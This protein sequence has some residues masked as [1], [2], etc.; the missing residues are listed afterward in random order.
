[1]VCADPED[2]RIVEGTYIYGIYQAFFISIY[3]FV[4][5]LCSRIIILHWLDE[6]K[7]SL[8]T[9]R[10]Q[11]VFCLAVGAT[12]RA[13]SFIDADCVTEEI[14]RFLKDV[15]WM[16][17]FVLIV[18]FWVELQT[19]VQRMS[20]IEKLK[21]YL[22]GI[23]SMYCFFR[24]LTSLAELYFEGLKN[25]FN[26]LTV[27][28]YLS[29]MVIGQYYG[30]KLLKK[31][32][33]IANKEFK[34]QLIRLTIFIILE[35]IVLLLLLG[36]FVI[37]TFFFSSAKDDKP[38]LWFWL[39]TVEKVLEVISIIVLCLTM[40]GK[41]SAKKKP[42]KAPPVVASSAVRRGRRKKGTSTEAKAKAGETVVKE[43]PVKA[44]ASS[45]ALL[46]PESNS[47]AAVELTPVGATAPS[48]AAA[49]APDADA[50]ASASTSTS[51]S[52]NP[53]DKAE[54]AVAEP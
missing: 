50:S 51:T 7:L 39:K 4:G 53:G 24:F 48:A 6:K 43:N 21:P 18:L 23:M 17:A 30:Q 3:L 40:V 26:G 15:F 14:F 16:A 46:K 41:S 27:L 47:G 10:Y 19:R 42:S 29:V 37:R 52:A 20:G 31:M 36:A 45:T 8:K 9:N 5:F 12:V 38:W 44:G 2:K 32:S 1:M 54:A 25:A 49:A 34:A 33:Q 22:I 13:L 28:I 11:V 35:N